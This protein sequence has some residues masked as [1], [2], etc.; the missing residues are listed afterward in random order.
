MPPLKELPMLKKLSMIL[1]K[2]LKI[3]KLNVLKIKLFGKTF[4]ITSLPNSLPPAELCI[5]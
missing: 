2:E 1:F 5:F 3:E 4:T